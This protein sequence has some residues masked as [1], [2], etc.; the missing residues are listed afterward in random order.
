VDALGFYYQLDPII[1]PHREHFGADMIAHQESEAWSPLADLYDQGFLDPV[2]EID[3]QI[4][5]ISVAFP[6]QAAEAMRL[7]RKVRERDPL[8][9]I[10]LGGPLV[11]LYADKWLDDDWVFRYVD[12][13]CVGDGETA[14]TELAEARGGLRAWSDVRNLVWRDAEGATVRNSAQPYLEPMDTLPVPDFKTADMGLYLTPRP[15]YPLMLSRGCY[16][17]RCTFCSIGWRENY[18]ASSPAKIRTDVLD[19]VNT[20]GARYIQVQDSSIPPS[21]AR[22]LAR[23]VKDENLDVSWGGGMKF[24]TCFTQE[25]YCR[26][27]GEGR[28][29]S[30]L[31]GFESANQEVLDL[32]DK[33]YLLEHCDAMLTNLR[34]SGVSVEMLWFIGF[35]TEERKDV[36]STARYLYDRRHLFGLTAFVG[37]YLLHPDTIVFERP[38]DFG[39]TVIGLDNDHCQYV[40]AKGIQPEEAQELKRLLASNNNRTLV[41]SGSQIPHLAEGGLDLSGLERPMTVPEEVVAFCEPVN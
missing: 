9:H 18:R 5:A 39:V 34:A 26:D 27:L 36:L 8:V 7:A 6:E 29:V 31:M 4:V 32:M 23:I 20:Y 30:L 13:V 37:D 14:I 40:V 11:S 19:L 12:T 17:G 2:F 41:C 3:P 25:D 38:E 1:S 35:P 33:G 22:Q 10:C 21:S 15:I 24:E 28:C 16:W